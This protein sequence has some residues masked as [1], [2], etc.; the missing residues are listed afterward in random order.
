MRILILIILAAITASCAS[1][2]ASR[3]SD[4]T[5]ELIE[6]T[7][8]TED[9][10]AVKNAVIFVDGYPTAAR[11]N[12]HGYFSLGIKYDADTVAVYSESHGSEKTAYSGQDNINFTLAGSFNA[13]LTIPDEDEDMVDIGYGKASRRNLTT[14]VGSVSKRKIDQ[15]HYSDIYSMIQGE[16]PGVTVTGNRIIIRG[17]GTMNAETDPLFVVDG[18]R[19]RTI[20]HI[21]PSDV[22][23]IDILKG[24]AASIYG[25]NGANGVILI[26]TKKASRK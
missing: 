4:D 1:R 26:N 9:G 24:P 14:T 10:S 21:N 23:S 13:N 6:G 22:A 3:S 17:V 20:D 19:M 25:V 2:I 7:V 5:L 18:V 15:P 8:S 12:S 11:S 16:V